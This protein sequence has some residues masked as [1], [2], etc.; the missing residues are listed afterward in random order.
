MALLE[1]FRRP[2][3]KETIAVPAQRPARRVTEAKLLDDVVAE[4]KEIDRRTGIERTLAI[5]ELILNQF[6]AGDSAIWRDRRRNKNNSIRRLAEREDCPFC[7][8][9]LNEAVGVYV[10]VVGLPCVRTFGHISASHV[11]SVLR[12]PPTERQEVLQEAERG[13]WSVRE[14]RQRVVT[15]RRAE[16]ERRG[17]PPDLRERR[18]ISS[19][20]QKLNQL[21][22]TIDEIE[23]SRGEGPEFLEELRTLAER[24]GQQRFRMLQ[25]ADGTTGRPVR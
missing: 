2:P 1:G 22:D 20:R 21:E 15:R 11:A 7:R 14:L 16:G 3:R 4:L 18:Y 23:S 19:L 13:Q 9:A 10:A 12:L 6:F 8:S 25:L 17:R 5:G 24:L